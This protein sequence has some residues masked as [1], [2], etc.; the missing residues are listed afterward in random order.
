MPAVGTCTGAAEVV[1]GM[2]SPLLGGCRV[3]DAMV[4]RGQVPPHHRDP[5]T[6]GASG[7]HVDGQAHQGT[8]E[9]TG[10]DGGQLGRRGQ[11]RPGQPALRAGAVTVTGR[12][13]AVPPAGLPS[14]VLPAAAGPGPRGGPFFTCPPRRAPG[15]AG[16]AGCGAGRRR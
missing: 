8:P 7:R 4:E 9:V 2:T 13:P 16:G 1:W 14:P 10:A 6:A 5:V 15:R 3:H 12:T 11:P